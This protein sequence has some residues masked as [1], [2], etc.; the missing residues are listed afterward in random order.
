LSNSNKN[1]IIFHVKQPGV[2]MTGFTTISH[3]QTNS[4]FYTNLQEALCLYKEIECFKINQLFQ[5]NFSSTLGIERSIRKNLKVSQTNIVRAQPKNDV[6]NEQTT[7]IQHISPDM[8]VCPSEMTDILNLM[9]TTEVEAL[10][11]K[12]TL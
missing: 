5:S 10:I 3:L 11:D 7:V 1:Y 8:H 6:S 9:N 4:Y 2:M 12:T